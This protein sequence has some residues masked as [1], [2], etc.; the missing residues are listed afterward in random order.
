MTAI[1]ALA[2]AGASCATAGPAVGPAPFPG[3]PRVAPPA[4][5]IESAE[6]RRLGA[7]VVRRALALRGTPYRLGGERPE[8]GLDCSGLVR[9]V[10]LEARVPLPRTVAHQFT[11][12]TRVSRDAMKPGDLVFFDITAPNPSHVGIVVD[13][14]AFVH[15]PGS[16]G[17][18]RVDRL[19]APYWESRLRAIRRVPVEVGRMPE[20]STPAN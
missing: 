3:S 17:A 19:S 1:L 6:S 10:F 13:E 12:G 18:V 16:G 11:V 8:T 15:A 20:D 4:A 9:H 2:I 14:D 5:A 7:D